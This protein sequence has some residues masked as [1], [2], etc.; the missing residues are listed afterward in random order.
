MYAKGM[1]YSLIHLTKVELWGFYTILYMINHR[2]TRHNF[3]T[4]YGVNGLCWASKWQD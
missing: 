3:W 4:G 2:M 1:Q